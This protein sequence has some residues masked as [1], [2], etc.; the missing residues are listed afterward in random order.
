MAKT[1]RPNFKLLKPVLTKKK[2][3]LPYGFS[4]EYSDD[5]KQ[6]ISVCYDYC[7]VKSDK[8]LYGIKEGDIRAVLNQVVELI[9]GLYAIQDIKPT[10]VN[11]LFSNLDSM[12][13]KLID[14]LKK[15]KAMKEAENK[16][17]DD[18]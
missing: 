15:R 8:D 3:N 17:S 14:E 2:Q 5:G 11:E 1:K 7:R 10:E 12:Y 18:K 16:S 4:Y 6:I 13:D 9:T